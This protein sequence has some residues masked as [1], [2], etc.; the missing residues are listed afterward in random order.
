MGIKEF[1]KP[2]KRKL[3][4]FVILGILSF[5]IGI[6]RGCSSCCP[7]WAQCLILMCCP[8]YS[9]I[10][11]PFYLVFGPAFPLLLVTSV[12]YWY[13]ISCVVVWGYDKIKGERS[14]TA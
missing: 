1:L 5:S 7:P 8:D 9:P 2:D 12:P 3:I 6:D 11:W 4:I 13:L 10:F 14:E